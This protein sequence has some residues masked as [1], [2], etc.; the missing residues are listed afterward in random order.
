MT[1]TSVLLQELITNL[2]IKP[3]D[4]VVDAT[5]NG[6]GVSEAI[7]VL[8][9]KQG[10][11]IG[12]DLDEDALKEAQSR[13]SNASCRVILVEGNY[14]NLNQI[15]S[16]NHIANI[17]RIFFDLGL[18]SRQL[19]ESGRGFSFKRDEPL[20][21]TFT[22]HPGEDQLTASTIVN[23]WSEEHIADILLGYGEEKNALRIAR[24][25][26]RRRKL[27]P[28]TTTLEL[29]AAIKEATP[30]SYQRKKIHCATKVFQAL[31]I[32]VNDE[33]EGLR[34]ALHTAYNRLTVNGRIGVISFHSI[35]DR[36]VKRAFKNWSEQNMGIVHTKKPIRPT[37][38]EVQNNPRSRSAKLR[39]FEKTTAC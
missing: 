11:L 22:K 38:E 28:I 36:I 1:H 34:E 26:V 24:E 8:L 27:E 39:I 18:S 32:T 12:I 17:H 30:L 7:T 6:G 2:E 20:L 5:I 10:T 37:E 23:D 31:R 16:D 4:F 25:I 19:G 15:L 21:M 35:E 3:E 29:V 13:L 9:N 33:I 14:R